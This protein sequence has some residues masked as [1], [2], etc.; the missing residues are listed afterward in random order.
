MLPHCHSERSEESKSCFY[1]GRDPSS[2]FQG[3]TPQDDS[4]EELP[5]NDTQG[6]SG[7]DKK[8]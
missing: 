4:G 7:K 5:Q 1:P 2:S 6:I 8:L 3:S